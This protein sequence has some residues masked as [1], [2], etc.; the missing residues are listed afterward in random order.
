[1]TNESDPN[2]RTPSTRWGWTP[3][4]IAPAPQAEHTA[5]AQRAPKTLFIPLKP[6]QAV[7]FT[8]K[9]R[10]GEECWYEITARGATVRRPG[11]L[12]LHDVFGPFWGGTLP[13]SK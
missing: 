7:N 8:V 9:F 4:K 12:A 13:G 11:V 2:E 5:R 1:M 10:G 6:R 3:I